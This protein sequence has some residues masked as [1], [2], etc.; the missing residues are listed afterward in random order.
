MISLLSFPL[1]FGMLSAPFPFIV[2]SFVL[3]MLAVYRHSAN[4]ERLAQGRENKV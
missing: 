4:I 1:F 2:V 3:A